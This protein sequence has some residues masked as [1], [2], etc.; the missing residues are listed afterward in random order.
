MLTKRVFVWTQL[1]TLEKIHRYRSKIFIELN[2][3]DMSKS[4]AAYKS[5]EM[6]IQKKIVNEKVSPNYFSPIFRSTTLYYDRAWHNL[7]DPGFFLYN[8]VLCENITNLVKI[9]TTLFLLVFHTQ[10]YHASTQ[11]T[12]FTMAIVVNR[13]AGN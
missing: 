7:F 13:V 2:F 1:K 5:I 11:T 9:Y 3:C 8:F 10:R 4:P 6:L 12:V